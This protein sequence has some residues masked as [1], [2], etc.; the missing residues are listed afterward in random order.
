MFLKCLIFGLLYSL[1]A[2]AVTY[3]RQV[4][5]LTDLFC[6]Y[7]LRL[8][9]AAVY[10]IRTYLLSDLLSDLLSALIYYLIYYSHFSSMLTDCSIIA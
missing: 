8:C 6:Q 10:L 5:L 9:S 3:S 4:M 2:Y 7:R 1:S